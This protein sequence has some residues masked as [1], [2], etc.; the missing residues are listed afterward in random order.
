MQ[1]L[2]GQVI[3]FKTQE[4]MRL[5]TYQHPII[6]QTLK[7]GK[8][9]TCSWE[10]IDNGSYW[11][12]S[13]QFMCQK[14]A[15]NNIPIGENPPIWVWHSVN[16]I[17]GMPDDDCARALMSDVQL[18]QGIDL[19]QLEV[20][21]NLVLLSNYGT[22][23]SILDVF[24]EKKVPNEEEIEDCFTL[25]L[26]RKRGR[27]RKYFQDIQACLPYIEPEWLVKKE[28]FDNKKFLGT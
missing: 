9:F 27:P 6:H 22:W 28:I 23:N 16:C 25:Q 4:T 10:N 19:L 15:E 12:T 8:R 17:G 24:Y 26:K 18:E 13:F 21:D 11:A 2:Q 5:W 1:R 7:S 3:F 14:M 20:P